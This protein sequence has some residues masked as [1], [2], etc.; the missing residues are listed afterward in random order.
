MLARALPG[1]LPPLTH[2]EVLEVT[3]IH[4]TA[5]DLRNGEAIHHPPF[6][7]PHHT[8]SHTAIVGGGAYPR[9]GEVTLAHKGV[10]FLDEFPEFEARALEAL[11]QPLEDRV[12][13]VSR[14]RASVTFPA[15]C[16]IVAAMNPADTLSADSEV[17]VRQALKQARKISRPIVD[18]LDLWVEVSHIP[19]EKLTAL[20]EGEGSDAVRSRVLAARARAR[21]RTG[22]EDMANARLSGKELDEKSKFTTEAKDALTQ[23]AKKLDLS[24]RSYHRIMRVA[25]TIADL[26]GSESVLPPHVFEAL[27]YRPRGLFGFE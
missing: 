19:H 2:D 26:A 20:A 4:S 25:R 22:K 7:A 11:R 3:A 12:V 9:A 27:Q 1:I 13:T 15:D 6:R 14:A 24:P 8:T 17:A 18:R 10:L 16:M 5:G 23:A 21:A